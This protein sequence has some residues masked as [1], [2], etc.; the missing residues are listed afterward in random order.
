MTPAATRLRDYFKRRLLG[1]PVGEAIMYRWLAGDTISYLARD[2]GLHA[3]E[4]E[5]M[6][7]YGVNYT[8]RLRRR[9]APGPRGEFLTRK[10]GSNT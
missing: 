4:V 3:N 1:M 5:N 10:T 6:V 7:R 2:F 9:R 8:L